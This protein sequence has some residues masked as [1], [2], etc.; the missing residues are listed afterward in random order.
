MAGQL[1]PPPQSAS[2]SRKGKE[3][4][5]VVAEI[6]RLDEEIARDEMKI[7][8]RSEGKEE[9]EACYVVCSLTSSTF[10]SPI[11]IGLRLALFV[12]IRSI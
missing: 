4:E 9:A 7:E 12:L 2:G 11:Q 6:Q 1:K 8:G 3:R 5:N 10:V